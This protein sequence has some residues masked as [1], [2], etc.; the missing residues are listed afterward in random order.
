M[1]S[2]ENLLM[3]VK[4]NNYNFVDLQFKQYRSSTDI[5]R[6]HNVSTPCVGNGVVLMSIQGN[7]YNYDII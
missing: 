6:P 7:D 1:G 2:M 5:R 4:H 3:L